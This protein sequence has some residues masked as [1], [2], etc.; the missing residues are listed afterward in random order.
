MSVKKKTAEL[1]FTEACT[2][3]GVSPADL[4]ALREQGMAVCN[5]DRPH[6]TY[7]QDKLEITHRL[8]NLGKDRSWNT[9]TLAWYADLLFAAEIGRAILLPIHDGEIGSTPTPANWL[10]TSYA[11]AV[12][13]D[14]NQEP[15]KA[16]T[17][18]IAL[19]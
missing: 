13:D 11:V 17:A 10:E 16:D 8:L 19:L 4:A 6:Q 1:S 2:Y 7:P 9:A 18:I 15:G 14:F 5:V 3:L 12:L